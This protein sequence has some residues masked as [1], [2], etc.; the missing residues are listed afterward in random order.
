MTFYQS[1]LASAIA[2]FTGGLK[3]CNPT[4]GFWKPI[5]DALEIAK[6]LPQEFLYWVIFDYG[7]NAGPIHLERPNYLLKLVQSDDFKDWKNNRT[8]RIQGAYNR[9]RQSI[10][11]SVGEGIPLWHVISPPNAFPRV[12]CV[13]LSIQALQDPTLSDEVSG[14]YRGVV[15]GISDMAYVDLIGATDM[16][17][18]CPLFVQ[19]LQKKNLPIVL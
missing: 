6:V 4:S 17:K 5:V 2:L 10:A 7:E 9:A 15:N 11:H 18:E 16:Q 14:I 8:G 1:N 3:K 19:L 12:L 13:E